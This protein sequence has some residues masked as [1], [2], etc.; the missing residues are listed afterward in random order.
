[1]ALENANIV[2][3]KLSCTSFPCLSQGPPFPFS[4]LYFEYIFVTCKEVILTRMSFMVF[5][6]LQT[7]SEKILQQ[8]HKWHCLMRMDA[9][10]FIQATRA[11]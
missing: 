3:V 1:M 7:I 2:P 11:G 10:Q 8:F 6:Q 5:K 4:K 9:V